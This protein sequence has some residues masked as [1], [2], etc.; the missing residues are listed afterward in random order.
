[1]FF[2]R[3]MLGFSEAPS[4]PANPVL[5]PPGFRQKNVV[6]PP[7]SLLGAIFLAGALFAAAW[8]ADFPWGWE[9]VFTV[10]GVIGFVLT[11]C[12]SS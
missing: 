3:F 5:S 11:A 12:G 9:H 4:F 6:L 7:P 2:M 8:L 1:M 10:M